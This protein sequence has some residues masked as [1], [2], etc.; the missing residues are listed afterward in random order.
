MQLDVDAGGLD[1]RAQVVH[2][3][4]Q[5]GG[6]QVRRIDLDEQGAQCSQALA[7][8]TAEFVQARWPVRMTSA[9]FA[10]ARF[11]PVTVVQVVKAAA[12]AIDVQRFIWFPPGI[13]CSGETTVTDGLDASPLSSGASTP[14]VGQEHLSELQ[15]HLG[16]VLDGAKGPTRR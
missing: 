1:R 6:L 4:G 13:G 3:R 8:P 7:H 12:A 15:L 11:A 10:R 5:P 16:Y 9:S 2:H 14:Q